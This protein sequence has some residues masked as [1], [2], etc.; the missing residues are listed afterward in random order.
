MSNEN[1]R[2]VKVTINEEEKTYH[3][4]K[5]R[6]AQ[7]IEAQIAYNKALRKAVDSGAFL[8]KELYKKLE[9]DGT[10][11]K[12]MEAEQK[13]ILDKISDLEDKIRSG[14]L[15]LSELKNSGIEI[16]KLRAELRM[17]IA[18][19]NS[20]DLLTAESQA[21]NYRF[22]SYIVTCI[23]DENKNQAFSGFEAYEEN[24]DEEW[25]TDCVEALAEL[26][27]GLEKDHD[28]K[29]VE[30]R[31]LKKYGIINEE[32]RFIQDGELVDQEGRRIDDEGYFIDEEGHRINKSGHRVDENGDYLDSA[33]MLDD[34]GNPIVLKGEEKEGVEKGDKK[35]KTAPEKPKK[36]AT[37][38]K[39]A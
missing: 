30:N 34:D 24:A 11:T 2:E 20:E 22:Y 35:E 31:F 10:W 13:Q 29:Y 4:I 38:K 26:L 23:R 16:K 12:E 28:D 6:Q 32:N 25:A 7:H 18:S 5:P 15:R 14:G 39:T 19:K 3:V 17:L 37:P 33:P 8:R 9:E 36:R 1:Q 21:E 27:Y